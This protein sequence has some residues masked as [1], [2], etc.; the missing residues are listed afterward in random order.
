MSQESEILASF[1]SDHSPVLLSLKFNEFTL[2][3]KGWDIQNIKNA[4]I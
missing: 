2:I 3:K 4:T 1:K